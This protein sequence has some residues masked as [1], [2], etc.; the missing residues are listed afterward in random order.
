MESNIDY[1]S[2]KSRYKIMSIC[3]R[4]GAVV[5]ASWIDD[6]EVIIKKWP[7]SRKNSYFNE[8]KNLF[9]IKR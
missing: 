1:N 4:G 3:G 5:K 6:Q 8:K 2:Y 9:K 7:K